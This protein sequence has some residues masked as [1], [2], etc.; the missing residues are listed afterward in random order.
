MATLER[1]HVSKSEVVKKRSVSQKHTLFKMCQSCNFWH[2]KYDGWQHFSSFSKNGPWMRWRKKKKKK[3]RDFHCPPSFHHNNLYACPFAVV[4]PTTSFFFLH[5][6]QKG[7]SNFRIDPKGERERERHKG[8][9]PTGLFC[10]VVLLS[11]VSGSPHLFWRHWDV[12]SVWFF[13]FF[14]N[15]W[16]GGQKKSRGEV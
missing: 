8:G 11:F 10:A 5:S 4:S 6:S 12:A 13:F 15:L 1:R 3:K 16:S 2:I 14:L 7:S 9:N